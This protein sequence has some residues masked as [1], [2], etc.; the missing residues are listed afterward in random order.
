[1]DASRSF[2][3]VVPRTN[4]YHFLA[5]SYKLSSIPSRQSLLLGSYSRKNVVAMLQGKMSTYCRKERVN[6]NESE[7]HRFCSIIRVPESDFVKRLC[8]CKLKYYHRIHSRVEVLS[9]NV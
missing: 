6:I 9:I 3:W 8:Y 4:V 2:L 5:Q 1:L 7:P